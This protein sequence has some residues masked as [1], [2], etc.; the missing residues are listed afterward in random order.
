M[1]AKVGKI[2]FQ[3][4]ATTLRKAKTATLN[5]WARYAIAKQVLPGKKR[6]NLKFS[7]AVGIPLLPA[8]YGFLAGQDP[9]WSVECGAAHGRSHDHAGNTSMELRGSHAS[10][11]GS[12]SAHCR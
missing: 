5:D 1:I 4:V 8:D 3:V 12:R 2:S 7:T 10:D 9:Q 11:E 6:E